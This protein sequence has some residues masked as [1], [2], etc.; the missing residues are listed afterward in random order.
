LA[1]GY[2]FAMLSLG[3]LLGLGGGVLISQGAGEQE[4]EITGCFDVPDHQAEINGGGLM[5]AGI[6]LAATGIT[7]VVVGWNGY[8]APAGM[9][10][11]DAAVTAGMMLTSLGGATL[12]GGLGMLIADGSRGDLFRSRT[13]GPLM[14]IG[15]VSTAAGIPIWLTSLN[16][17][18]RTEAPAQPADALREPDDRSTAVGVTGVVFASLGAVGV[19]ASTIAAIGAG[20]IGGGFIGLIGAS[21][22]GGL[23]VASVPLIVMGFKDAPVGYEVRSQAAMGLGLTLLSLG[24]PAAVFGTIFSN[25][26]KIGSRHEPEAGMGLLIGGLTAMAAGLPLTVWGSWLVPEGRSAGWT[27]E[28]SVGPGGGEI[29]MRF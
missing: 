21:A 25:E 18:E 2:G 20:G 7:A 24:T 6:G 10:R 28:L 16:D 15:G 14:V 17:L 29:T 13:I 27:P 5:G 3:A 11:N 22:G 4:C 9:R 1:V 23:A 8:E 26:V 19:A 12:G